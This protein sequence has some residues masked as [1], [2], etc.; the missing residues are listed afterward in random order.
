[1]YKIRINPLALK[2]LLDIREY[3]IN[4]LNNSVSAVKVIEEIVQSYEK[5]RNFPMLGG[6]LTTKI[7]FL[8][9]Y[10]FLVSGDYIIFYKV[11]D[12]YVSIYRIL[13]AKRDYLRILFKD[14]GLEL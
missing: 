2:D 3:I 14:E 1:M 8:T 10:R 5:L 9:D 11:D 13:N 7:D 4:E 12:D 6:S